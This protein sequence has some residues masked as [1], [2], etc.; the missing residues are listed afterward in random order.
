MVE[1]DV[2]KL[3]EN[4]LISIR[5]GME[6]F[7]RSQTPEAQGG[8][9]A[10][11][12]SAV[13]N[14]FAG[15]LLLFKY[16][17][18]NSVEDLEDAG[19]LI[20]NPPEV[21]PFPDG[22]GGIEWKPAGKF[23]RTTIDVAAI[24]KR[25]EAF[26]IEVDWTKIDKMQECRNHL[27]HL[28]PANTLG[29]V[30]GF[31]ADL[32]PVVRDF[33]EVQL[34]KVPADLLGGAWP[35]MLEHHQFFAA[36]SKECEQAW[37]EAGVPD[38]MHRF[39]ASAKCDACGSALLRPHPEE[40][41]V[42]ERV[43]SAEDVFRYRCVACAHESLIAPLLVKALNNAYDYDHRDGGEEGVEECFAC[44]RDTFVIDEGHCF[45]CEAELEHPECT[46]CGESL[47]QD[48]QDN[49]GLCGYHAHQME[50]AMRE[51]KSARSA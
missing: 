18:A 1:L 28:H 20:F 29:E 22:N 51:D 24:R 50:K 47:R 43:S 21:M 12:L 31:V 45:W 15:V 38:D 11:A 2:E 7:Q 32:F 37:A 35:I 33:V 44:K 9:A 19:T 26:G 48:D 13:R 16:K 46:F 3:L 34:H 14:L 8:D 40:I 27:E 6:D 30:A 49:G 39:M 36:T 23:R 4:S 17:I 25:F 5:L 41:D 10:R 42:G